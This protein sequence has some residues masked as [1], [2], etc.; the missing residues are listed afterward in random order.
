MICELRKLAGKDKLPLAPLKIELATK[1][2]IRA[3]GYETPLQG[4]FTKVKQERYA[5]VAAAIKETRARFAD[6]LV[7]DIQ[8]KLFDALMEELQYE[9]LRRRHSR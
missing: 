9:I 2:E 5:A 7:D 4:L 8:K 6:V 3:Y 1:A